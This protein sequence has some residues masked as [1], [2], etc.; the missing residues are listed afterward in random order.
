MDNLSL[1][2]A[3]EAALRQIDDCTD[4]NELKNLTRVL[5]RS[6]FL[7][8]ATICNLLI[9]GLQDMSSNSNQR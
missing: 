9:Q 7:A 3:E 4:L 1:K 6:H 8:K 5:M 2:F